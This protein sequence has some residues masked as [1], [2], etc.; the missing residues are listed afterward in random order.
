MEG[1]LDAYV[2]GVRVKSLFDSII[3]YD[4]VDR[5]SPYSPLREFIGGSA[6]DL[7]HND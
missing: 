5:V 6:Y 1:R 2:R 4:D 3:A 7:A